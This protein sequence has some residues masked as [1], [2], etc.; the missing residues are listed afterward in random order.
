M[1]K[2]LIKSAF[3]YLGKI[4]TKYSP[5]ILI[6]FGITGLITTTITAVKATPKAIESIENRADELGVTSKELPIVE[7]VKVSWKCYI[8][9]AVLGATSTA[10]IIASNSVS[11]KRKAALVTAYKLSE[12]AFADYKDQVVTTIGEKKEEAI[13]DQVMKKVID[14]QPVS[15]RE[16]IITEKGTTLC[17][18]SL[19]G[20][21]F[22]STRDAIEK[23]VNEF[24]AELIN[25]NYLTI[26]DFYDYIGLNGTKTGDNLGWKYH[27]LGRNGLIKIRFSSHLADD[28]ET[29]C[30]AMEYEVPP[31]Y[32]GDSVF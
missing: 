11:T 4:T 18:E 5:E 16:V 1:N 27:G 6:A 31:E 8:P 7:K 30:L 20:R 15:N 14:R 17:F 9:S 13:R 2:T 32:I 3:K 28:G 29:P 26:N 19:S 24:N 22:R 12:A 10:C 23:A 25:N 21:Y